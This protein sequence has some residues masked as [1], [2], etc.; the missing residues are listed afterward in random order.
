MGKVKEN[1]IDR[2]N[3]LMGS[4]LPAVP[5]EAAQ[6]TDVPI[7]EPQKVIS[8]KEVLERHEQN[9]IIQK[10]ELKKIL[11]ELKNYE[12]KV[13]KAFTRLNKIPVLSVIQSK[14][15]K[16]S[17]AVRWR[18]TRSLG[19][20]EISL[21]KPKMGAISS[22][23]G[24]S[25]TQYSIVKQ[26]MFHLGDSSDIEAID[27]DEFLVTEDHEK[28]GEGVYL[29]SDLDEAK[30]INESESKEIIPVKVD[31]K[32][33][34]IVST[35]SPWSDHLKDNFENL[36]YDSVI[37]TTGKPRVF[38]LF[39][40]NTKIIKVLAEYEED[41]SIS[42]SDD[43][44]VV[45]DSSTLKILKC[46]LTDEDDEDDS[47]LISKAVIATP[48]DEHG[49]VDYDKVPKGQSIWI[50]VTKEG[51]PL[52]GR[53]ILITKRPDGLFA[54]TGGSGMR[55][56]KEKYGI[57]KPEDALRHLVMG[58]RPERT[59]RDVE[60]E[61][62]EEEAEIANEP[63][64]EK[65]K[66]LLIEEKKRI[67]EAYEDFN[68]AIGLGQTLTVG[69]LKERREELI[70]HAK[71]AG[72]SEDEGSSYI[73]AIIRHVAAKGRVMTERQRI[74][75]AMKLFDTNAKVRAMKDTD[76][77]GAQAAIDQAN[78]DLEGFRRK[79]P[80]E[81]PD[82]A[83]MKGLTKEQID[84]KVGDIINER[85][86]EIS[87]PDKTLD[88]E[89]KAEGLIPEDSPEG[90]KTVDFGGALKPLK[91]ENKEALQ[92]SVNKF[93]K[94]YET[95]AEV[96]EIRRLIKPKHLSEVTPA[97]LD[98]MRLDVK[99]TAPQLSDEDVMEIANSYDDA[100][101]KNNSALTFYNTLGDFWNDKVSINEKMAKTDNSFGEYVNSGGNAALAA[102]TGRFF[103]RRFDTS[104]LIEKT[105]IETAALTAAFHF[106]DE[107]QEN[108]SK[109]DKVI[110]D[111]G[112]YNAKN[113]V[114]TEQDALRQHEKLKGYYATIQSEKEKGTL[115]SKLFSEEYELNNLM[116]QR[117]NLATALGSMQASAAFLEALTVARDKEDVSTSIDFGSDMRSA[118]KRLNELNLG[119]K[120]Y[121]DPSDPNNIKIKT[122]IR[123]L[124]RF[125]KAQ[126]VIN[127]NYDE[128]EKI[129]NNM[130]NTDIDKEGRTYVKSYEVPFWRDK[131][132][133]PEGELQDHKFRVEQ[134]NDIEFLKKAGG[135]VIARTTGTGKTNT[136]LGFFANKIS[137][138][139]NYTALA[140]VPRGRVSQ[141][142][143]EA[144]KFT[145]IDVVEIPEG[146]NKEERDKII[147]QIKPGQVAIISQRD[148][149][150][151]Y[152]TLGAAVNKGLFKGM[153]IDEPQELA[154]RSVLGNMS[155]SVRKLTKL[156]V[157]NRIAL[158]A[159]PA[160][161]NLI[162]AYDLVNWASH[163]DKSLGPRARFQRIY[164]GY[165]SGTNAQ[166]A[167]LQQMIHKEISPFVSGEKL[168]NPNFKVKHDQVN[169]SKTS[170]QN[171]N[172]KVLER[173]VD[174]FIASKSEEYIKL[175]E[176]NPEEL[177]KWEKRHGRAW[178][179]Q[180]GAKARKKA[181]GEIL[182]RHLN[183][184]EGTFG[185]M[186]WKDNP[187]ISNAVD[188]I[189]KNRRDKHV[190][191]IDNPTQR[192]ALINGLTESGMKSS[193]IDNLATT[194][195]SGGIGGSEMAKRARKFR[196]D[197]SIKVLFIDRQSA[198]GY[199]L[200]EG[201]HLHVMGTPSDAA[202]YL[203][204]QGRLARMPRVGDVNV[205][206]Y[207]YTDVP[208][209]DQ[210]WV[211]IDQQLRILRAVAPGMFMGENK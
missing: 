92:D 52:Q 59:V 39:V 198:S 3:K 40:S 25:F 13:E 104:S 77:E 184:L 129:K 160:R 106:R 175:I 27:N 74:E 62:A 113:Q 78:E 35:F 133:N 23:Y 54:I 98:Q 56:F 82:P 145:N 187:K 179:N 66:E 22:R 43:Y 142:I 111:L 41:E 191:F 135:G 199:N 53:H 204:A 153:V 203:Q 44:E 205:R 138:D 180:A 88:G 91:I 162:E 11:K 208:F 31:V 163:H 200:Q 30:K 57:E 17:T 7:P 87:D 5:E 76:P 210:K 116:L 169:I 19:V 108:V 18:S 14:S 49:N 144:H 67:G 12:E 158:T 2:I 45:I 207:R 110:K 202:N 146:L 68:K 28:Y 194:V 140:V 70:R 182:N 117:K 96:D 122:S 73:S 171:E 132:T 6:D 170:I 93:R 51:S 105:S 155:A 190:I 71:R 128:N 168:T 126:E 37:I 120:A 167:T 69:K 157:E 16:Y 137:E 72:L 149:I 86:N 24:S 147:T 75:I 26:T 36:G 209:E 139:K 8:R 32:N 166:D 156:P 89:L 29:Y 55:H 185:K 197:P 100:Y 152:Y 127:Q 173:Q 90:I 34:Y 103:G 61:R 118:E 84:G 201:N 174:R 189:I 150:Y 181:R 38:T 196:E 9:P 112:E 115:S 15:G 193:H 154:S 192:R 109:Y 94:F 141:W 134:R 97:L 60:L 47:E 177:Q 4:P 186:G 131:I 99:A 143:D 79:I 148:A 64:I 48:Q 161:D 50:T 83:S 178:K 85:F 1:L 20:S 211:R 58:G 95:R 195:T 119:N 10:E 121:I 102:M 165:G 125:E 80:M 123:A 136:S 65:K 42:K 151:S 114:K 33:P 21:K 63:L 101:Q 176:D 159:T 172:M 183:N 164:G 107:F 206:T 124:Y 188:F 130:S 46:L 81:L